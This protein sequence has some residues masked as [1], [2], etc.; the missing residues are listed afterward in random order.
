MGTRS[1][2]I[3][4][5]QQTAKKLK[6]YCKEHRVKIADFVDQALMEKME[7]EEM[8]GDAKIF[9]LCRHEEADA[10]DYLDYLRERQKK[11]ILEF[12]V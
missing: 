5:S 1:Y 7:R 3:R 8:A 11:Q 9:A 10:I 6:G 4:I 2:I 12:D